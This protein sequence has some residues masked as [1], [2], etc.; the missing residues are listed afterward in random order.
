MKRI[1]IAALFVLLANP[2]VFADTDSGENPSMSTTQ[3]IK[4]TAQ[5]LAVDAA[6]HSV[7]LKGPQGG[8]RTIKLEQAQRL[9]EVEVGDTVMAEY[10]QHMNL[11]LVPGHGGRPGQ[12]TI[13]A[14]ARAPDDEQ[15]GMVASETTITMATVHEIDLENG[16]FKLQ[17][18]EGIKE[19]VARS[20]ENLKKAKVGDLVVVTY[21]EALMMQL[22][23]IPG[24]E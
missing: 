14:V 13:S 19:Y 18:E 21:T 24:G 10:V 12:G 1:L 4:L 22:Q 17:W 7:T 5:V 16:T 11:E 23:E 3:T 8:V 15:P 2:A 6:N 20:R 9:D